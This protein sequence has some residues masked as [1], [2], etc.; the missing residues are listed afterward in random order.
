MSNHKTSEHYG[1]ALSH[2]H[3]TGFAGVAEAAA[4]M[5]ICALKA[6]RLTHGRITDL[7]CGSGILARRLFDQGYTV[8]GVDQSVAML[9]LAQSRAPGAKF[10]HESLFE[11]EIG[12]SVAVCAI[13]ECFNY[14]FDR[15]NDDAAL[16][17]VLHRVHQSLE[18]GG[19]FLFDIATPDRIV[20][21]PA[22][23]FFQTQD[24]T[25]LV[26]NVRSEIPL[27]M[28]REISSFVRAGEYY[29]RVDETHSLRLI[30]PDTLAHSITTLG[31]EFEMFECYGPT[32]LPT[33][34][35]GF[36]AHKR[37]APGPDKVNRLRGNQAVLP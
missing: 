35:V 13:G 21:A 10:R 2:I 5:L 19:I 23:N 8:E 12:P 6:S 32:P 9:A 28:T 24:C 26:E 15:N 16:D 29:E 34:C 25:T 7:G 27:R 18:G 33:G 1:H 22:K 37:N 30:D 36:L 17:R 4:D 3:D 11:C 20:K 31:F 14:L